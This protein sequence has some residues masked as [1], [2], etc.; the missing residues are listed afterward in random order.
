[1]I[2]SVINDFKYILADQITEFNMALWDF[3]QFF[4][5]L[6]VKSKHWGRDKMA[7]I[8]Q[9]TFWYVSTYMKSVVFWLKF[10]W[11]LF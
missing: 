6:N 2:L 3:K 8:L 7:A 5:T 10:Q 9:M 1:M 4:G 11:L